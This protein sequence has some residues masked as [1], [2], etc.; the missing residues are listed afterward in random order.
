LKR[1]F[2]GKKN[3]L[4]S[5]YGILL[6]EP[7]QLQP[8]FQLWL[9]FPHT[10]VHTSITAMKI[11]HNLIQLPLLSF[12]ILLLPPT[13][14]TQETG[15]CKPHTW[16]A[17]NPKST[18]TAWKKNKASLSVSNIGKPQTGQVNCRFPGSTPKFVDIDTCARLAARYN[19]TLKKFYMLNPELDAGCGN[20]EPETD[21]CVAGCTPPPPSLR[22]FYLNT[23]QETS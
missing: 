14:L 9:S 15:T 7:S 20:I 2:L 13:A 17:S 1:G 23:W 22:V 8:S 19:I 4:I 10:H 11:F 18:P 16:S 6:V 3:V 5:G 12:A 21:Y